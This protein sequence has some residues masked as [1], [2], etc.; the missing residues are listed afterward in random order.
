LMK[1]EILRLFILMWSIVFGVYYCVGTHGIFAI[2][3]LQQMNK[4][5]QLEIEVLTGRVTHLKESIDS[6]ERESFLKE[7]LAREQLQLAYPGDTVYY[8]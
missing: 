1:V 3:G 5:L 6:W 7:Q 4:Q 8:L 2:H